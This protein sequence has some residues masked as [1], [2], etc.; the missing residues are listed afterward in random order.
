VA[1]ILIAAIVGGG[2][3]TGVTLGIL[4]LQSRTNPQSVD[5]GSRVTVTEDNAIATVAQKAAPAVVSVTAQG[6]SA[7]LASGFLVT[8]DGY[9]VTNVAAIANAA[10]LS[11]LVTGD[12]RRHDARIVDYDCETGVAVLKVDQVSNEPT[13]AFGDSAGLKIGQNVVAV[14]GPLGDR[15]SRGVVGSLH[16]ALLLDG[17]ATAGAQVTDVIQT[18][19]RLA[20]DVSGGPLLNLGG[21]VVGVTAAGASGGQPVSYAL[22]ASFIRPEVEQIVQ[23]G[24]LVVPTLGIQTSEVTAE[25]AALRGGTAGAL[26]VVV[27]AGEP[28][29]VAGLKQ[30]DVITALDDVKLDAAHPLGEVLRTLYRPA[31]RVNVTYSRGGTSDQKQ[32]T[33]A[34]EHPRCQ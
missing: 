24:Q 22:S 5:L 33:L 20:P 32:V 15:V 14:G 3:A 2:V 7:G 27:R 18:D 16:R 19:S 10:G 17:S 23:S 26:V 6:R 8:S 31:Q 34:G 13:L 28:A 1:S 25:E 30:G 29:E 21:Q 9:I 11:V 12:A 4:R